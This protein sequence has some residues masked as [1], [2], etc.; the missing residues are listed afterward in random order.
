MVDCNDV[1]I[2]CVEDDESLAKLLQQSL[3]KQHHQVELATDGQTGWGLVETFAYD[4]ILLDWMLPKLSGIEFCQRLRAAPHSVSNPNRD[5]P[6][7]LMTALDAVT[8][9]VMGLN[10]GADDYVVKPF[11]LDELLARIRALLRRR[12]GVRS[13][14]LQWGQLCLNSN[15]G[16]V[17]YQKQPILLTAKEYELLE[18]FLRNPEQIFSIERLLFNL[19]ATEEL[20]S[21]GAV[22]THIKSLR[23]KLKQAGADD[24][25]ETIYKRGYRLNQQK[26]TADGEK[27][28]ATREDTAERKNKT[29]REDTA[30]RKDQ[31]HIVLPSFSVPPE[32]WNVWQECQQSYSDRLLVVQH[33]ITALQN[34]TLTAAQQ[35]QATQEVHTLIGSL[36]SF[37]LAEAS[38][39]SR[40]IQ[41]L[42]K[43]QPPLT[44]SETQ[45]LSQLVTTLRL[46]LE[47]VGKETVER[48]TATNQEPSPI[49][50][51]ILPSLLI[52]DDDL[53]LTHLLAKEA[54][55]WRLQAKVAAT[56]HDAQQFLLDGSVDIMLLDI[57]FSDSTGNGLD[58]LAMVR[59]QHPHIPVVMLTAEETLEKRVEAARLGSQCFL[60]KP[61]IPAQALSAVSQVLQ[62]IS[63]SAAQILV[64]DDDSALLQ[65]LRTLLEP[66]GYQVTGLNEPQHFWQ[67][68]EQTSPDLLILDVEFGQSASES[69]P[70]TTSDPEPTTVP[71][72]SGFELCQVIRSDPHWN[73]LPVLFLSTHTDVKTVQRSFAVGADDFLTKPVIYQELLARVRTRLK[74]RTLWKTTDLD[75]LTGVSLR[76]KAQEDLTWLIRL[77]QRQNQ[78]F[79]LAVLDLDHFKQINDQYGHAVGDQVLSYLGHLFQQSF[80]QE[81]IVG[82]WGGEEFIIGMYGLTKQDGLKRLEEVLSQL[83]QHVFLVQNGASFQMTFSAGIA[84]LADDGDEL[85]TLYRCADHALYQA[86]S[87]GRNQILAARSSHSSD[88]IPSVERQQQRPL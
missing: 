8:S 55:S 53:P 62:Q 72:L 16:E 42:L 49:S 40:Q 9:K 44:Q 45:H 5:T 68:L 31:Q 60:Q 38:Q 85:Q 27:E 25:I 15:S 74:Q 7:L 32:L 1:R 81:D 46:Y 86:K 10:A 47:N 56:L 77:A 13:P 70:K 79:S 22:R 64:V 36:G 65:L 3:A 35:Q 48:E 87:A 26:I 29:E 18:L 23:H 80:R 37:G 28:I 41:R 20:P 11:N 84:Q 39:I 83:K 34:G 30:E 71:S 88:F 52:V 12:Q 57:N 14:L 4:L 21:E 24:P 17:A 58:F 43:Q 59:E 54:F 75:E 61:I 78:P 6:I 66:C 76:R 69:D 73:R 33:T 67:T 19:W 2:L 82:R 63:H 50:S 51:A